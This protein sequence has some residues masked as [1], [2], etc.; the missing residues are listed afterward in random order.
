MKKKREQ[1]EAALATKMDSLSRYPGVQRQ[2]MDYCFKTY[3]I[4]RSLIMDIFT[5]RKSVEEL[6]EFEL[7]SI[8]D[9]IDYYYNTVKK[10]VTNY[11]KKYFTTDEIKVLAKE[12]YQSNELQF[13]LKI[14]CIEINHNQWIGGADVQFL[15]RLKKAGLIRYN[16]NAQRTLRRKIINGE[17]TYR[18]TLNKTAV[19]SIKKR[20]DENIFVPNTI[21]LNIPDDEYD[22]MYD[23]K[24]KELVITSLDH[25]DIPDGYHRYVAMGQKYSLDP[26][27][28]WPIEL[29][30]VKFSDAQ[31]R[32][33]IYQEDQKTKMKRLDSSSM[34][35]VA[36]ENVCLEKLNTDIMFNL[37]GEISR[38]KGNLNF[39]ELAD[40]V[41]YLYFLPST[42]KGININKRIAEIEKSLLTDINDLT[43]I[44]DSLLTHRFTFAEMVTMVYGF[45]QIKEKNRQE[46]LKQIA[47]WIETA[48]DDL[49]A[50]I[51]GR[52]KTSLALINNIKNTFLKKGGE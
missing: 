21:T 7:F 1:L 48:N 20:F 16:E 49:D 18:I 42:L 24:N 22:F 13:P 43:N 45:T 6:T 11:V 44:D 9:G 27:W 30:I 40:I 25:F 46:A 52:K 15:M 4:P 17:E 5:F 47:K 19:N 38:N 51:V 41:R 23:A 2:V 37:K 35:M 31:I 26:S 32:D 50:N 33:F 34:N 36:P 8:V 29:R 10:E 28:N 3:Q 39:S 12:K 14:S